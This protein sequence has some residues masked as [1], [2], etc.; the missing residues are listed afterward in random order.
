MKTS[1]IAFWIATG[2]VSVAFLGSGIANLVHAPHIA[3][4][5]ARLGY[6]AYFSTILGAWKVFGAIAIVAPRL[7]RLK[8]WAYAGMIFDLSGAAISRGVSGDGAAGIVPPVIVAAFVVAS[9][10]LR[11]ED[12]FLAATIPQGSSR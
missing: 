3:A 8:E 7:P 9:W 11:T 10:A 5:M 4:D 1:K 2:V 6:P 12:R